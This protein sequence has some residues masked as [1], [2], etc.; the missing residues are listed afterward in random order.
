MRA[1]EK[2][3]A[4]R[5]QY[6]GEMLDVV[7]RLEKEVAAVPSSRPDE[8]DATVTLDRPPMRATPPV[9]RRARACSSVFC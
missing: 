6:A 4:H 3:P 2:D 7:E 5:P 9:R 1:M 8:D